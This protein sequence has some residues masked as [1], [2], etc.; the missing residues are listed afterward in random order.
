MMEKQKTDLMAS[1]SLDSKFE[2]NWYEWFD[3]PNALNRDRSVCRSNDIVL[4]NDAA[5]HDDDQLLLQCSLE[6]GKLPL[7]SEDIEDIGA[8]THV[9]EPFAFETNARTG[10]VDVQKFVEISRNG[11]S[12]RQEDA[13]VS[14][15]LF[16]LPGDRADFARGNS[17]NVPFAPGGLV[18]KK[19][20]KMRTICASSSSSSSSSSCSL[21]DVASMLTDAPGF[22][23]SVRF[24]DNELVEISRVA[25]RQLDGDE[26]IVSLNIGDD[27][28]EEEDEEED[29]EEEENDSEGDNVV[30][31]IEEKEKEKD[32]DND[33]D[34]EVVEEEL[35]LLLSGDGVDFWS[36]LAARKKRAKE[37]GDADDDD[38]WVVTERVDVSRFAQ[39]VPEMAI[40]YPFDL[41]VFQKEAVAHLER[42]E[43]V[44]VAAHT[45]AGKTVV[46]E[47]AIALAAKH[48][49]RALYTSPIKALSNQKFR[50]FK[51][52]F[53]DVGL[54]TGDVQVSPEASCLVLT[55]EILRSML[56][57][58]ADLIRDVEWVIFDEVHYI[59]DAERGV[60]WEEVIIMLPD[61]V[62]LI[63]LSATVPN[64]YEFADWVGRTKKKKV[65]VISTDKRPTPL[66]HY[67]A[68]EDQLFKVLDNKNNFLT[69]GFRSAA[70]QFREH[71]KAPSSAAKSGGG[72]AARSR[73]GNRQSK[74]H[75]RSAVVAAASSN[76]S[77]SS[78]Q[79]GLRS[80]RNR[81]IKMAHMLRKEDLLP[82][83]VFVFSR[84]R[85]EEIAQGLSSL[86]FSSGA[87]KAAVHQFVEASLA[88]LS[89]AD[90]SVRQVAQMRDLL[91]RGI[92]VHHSGIISI[93]KEVVEILFTRGLI[94]LLFA[95]ETFAMG[96]NAPARTVVFDSL[97]KHD[98][99]SMRELLAGE[100]TQMA[101]RA[102]RR[103]IDKVGTVIVNC[104]RSMPDVSVFN[105]IMCG[106]ATKLSSQFRLTYN[107][108][109]NLLR[110]QDFR[111]EDMIKRSFS[112]VHAQRSVPA[113]QRVLERSEQLL[114]DIEDVHCIMGEP[115]IERYY[116]AASQCRA[117]ERDLMAH[118]IESGRAHR[119][120]RVGTLVRVAERRRA[121]GSHPF[122]AI[123]R[124][125]SVIDGG[126]ELLAF[127]IVAPLPPS[128]LAAG[129]KGAGGKAADTFELLEAVPIYALDGIARARIKKLASTS[130]RSAVA[131]Q[132]RRMIRFDEFGDAADVD[133]LDPIDDFDVDAIDFVER[134]EIRERLR[135]DMGANKCHECPKLREHYA[136]TERRAKLAERIGQLRFALSDRNLLL[137]PE[138]DARLGVLQALSYVD[139]GN[140]VLMKGRVAREFNTCTCEL[141][142]TELVFDNAL[143]ELEPPE[144]AALFSALVFQ[145]SAD[146]APLVPRLHAI[147]DKMSEHAERLGH[148]QV[149]ARIPISIDDY[150][151]DSLHF[152]LVEVVDAWARG[153]P[154]A[155]ICLLTDV[156]EGSIVRAIS[157]LGETMKELRNAA[158]IIG[159]S[160]LYAK[161]EQASS[162]IKRDIIFVSSLY[163]R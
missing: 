58:G 72:G 144:I 126:A 98:G 139:A 92:G 148:L 163:V 24:A 32:D 77:S 87:E 133:M 111:V 36:M 29:E 37:R 1:T 102:G 143:A 95:T 155:E 152:G 38:E 45:S 26:A 75:K 162:L 151:R 110:V 52:R 137:M 50:D 93:V 146:Y 12:E 96:V 85:C 104:W 100:Y 40:E 90:R 121:T 113:Q 69:L 34:D 60:V 70:R 132:V 159:S 84:R 103:G 107:M 46:A 142:A 101:G 67:V 65:W 55:T 31:D 66:E 28:S 56:Y 3:D 78:R 9:Q 13:N 127:D 49:T 149:D 10:A 140:A 124:T 68:I 88:R 2:R 123:V 33:D 135:A 129:A 64:T 94:K 11:A 119:L 120:L 22:E 99:R 73:G 74:Q 114:G 20:Q 23:F 122:G 53:G 44:L 81:W 158:R 83:V 42:N 130:N 112:E 25:P 41:D 125:T 39:L 153:V 8:A 27:D 16:R 79:A 91:K 145:Q 21:F 54:I 63:F 19:R 105:K 136:A 57:K 71:S 76:A 147:A 116:G 62:N 61:H 150:K 160:E 115:D 86:D 156:Q 14:T 18:A 157:R 4:G 89:D 141:L 15:S 128:E 35:N 43:S 59:R 48:M 109:L 47:Y 154:F 30:D 51:D 108:I 80:N 6:I 117:L 106:R 138:F 17:Q 131:E 134:A 82:G 161:A 7:T 5:A 118:V 97:E